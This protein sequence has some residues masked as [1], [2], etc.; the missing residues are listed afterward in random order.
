MLPLELM[1]GEL[2]EMVM[3]LDVAPNTLYAWLKVRRSTPL[4][5][6]P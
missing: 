1:W 3:A 4:N 5:H 2:I 6:S